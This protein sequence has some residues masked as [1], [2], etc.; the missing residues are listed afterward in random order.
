[1][2]E[3]KNEKGRRPLWPH[4]LALPVLVAVVWWAFHWQLSALQWLGLLLIAVVLWHAVQ[5]RGRKRGR[6]GPAVRWA[7][8]GAVVTA[9]LATLPLDQPWRAPWFPGS[10]LAGSV[11]D[12]CEVAAERAAVLVPEASAPE[13]GGYRD[14]A[15]DQRTCG[16]QDEQRLLYL[17]YR[18]FPWQGTDDRSV[19]SAERAF[20]ERREHAEAETLAIGDE[21]YREGRDGTRITVQARRAN[22]VVD[23][24][25]YALDGAAPLGEAEAGDLR[26][27]AEEAVAAVTTG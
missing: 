18:L 8:A 17:T 2:S 4:A 5:G 15:T 6:M 23:I 19:A 10:G 14:I 3:E 13:T 11:P 26:R 21:A 27:L 24:K 9:V 22:V 1:M 25:L 12:P 16:W 20:A 7:A